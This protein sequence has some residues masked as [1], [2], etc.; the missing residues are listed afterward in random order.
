MN[1]DSYAALYGPV[2]PV[3]T[4]RRGQTGIA[5]LAGVVWA[6]VLVLLAWPATMVFV[7]VLFGAA[8]G[9][10]VGGLLLWSMLVALG[11]LGGPVALTFVPPARRLSVPARFLL[12]GG[13][14]LPLAFG[15]VVWLAT[16]GG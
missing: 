5:I 2:R 9:R 14:T 12:A 8:G 13:V 3:P 7:S 6:V 4:P 15:I 1:A 11:A 10:P 16:R